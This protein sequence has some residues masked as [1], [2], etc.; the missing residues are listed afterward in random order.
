M[1]WSRGGESLDEVK[2]IKEKSIELFIKGGFKLHKWNSNVP[3]SLE[4]KGAE[5]K[6]ELT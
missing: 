6:Q 5:E 2:I 4:N 3:P 1:T